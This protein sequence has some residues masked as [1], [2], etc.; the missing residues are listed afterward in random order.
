MLAVAI[1]AHRRIPDASL[2]SHT[3]NTLF[4]LAT[5]FLMALRARFGHLPVVYLRARILRRV[6]IVIPVAVV[7][8]G[9]LFV[10]SGG[11]A[12]VH[13]LFIR[14]HRMSERNHVARQKSRVAMA[15]GA[16]IRKIRARNG[17]IGHAR[18]F[19]FVNCAVARNALR[20]V[21]VNFCGGLPV[22]AGGK[23][24]DLIGVAFRAFPRCK[25]FGG[26]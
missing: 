18:S 22:N 20:C 12:A 21:A 6:D 2:N 13:A 17:R 16:G 14:L 3:V 24:L 23:L 10:T 11:C 8:I 25:I 1:C 15:L 9:G 5:N 7:A 4:V 26:S 19:R